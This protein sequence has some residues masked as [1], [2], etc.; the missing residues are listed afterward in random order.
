MSEN[1]NTEKTK[2]SEIVR[3]LSTYEADPSAGNVSA[4]NAFLAKI[5]PRPFRPLADKCA[6]VIQIIAAASGEDGYAYI[7]S[8]EIAKTVYGLLPYIPDFENDLGDAASDP[9]VYDLI[10]RA[11]FGDYLK[12]FC[13]SDYSVLCGMV[14]DAVNYSDIV[15]LGEMAKS[16]TPE[17]VDE[18]IKSVRSIKD[19]P[20]EK[21]QAL[22]KIATEGDPAWASLKG[23]VADQAVADTMKKDLLDARPES[24]K[25]AG[26]KAVKEYEQQKQEAKASDK[27]TPKA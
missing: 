22:S 25:E 16:I 1:A 11:G 18:F 15:R 26:E 9:S 4:Y 3:Q 5:N 6:A 8:L 2:F 20:P 19:L 17:S 21:L 12:G 10:W 24:E 14:S 27:E 23:S 13:Q 7:M